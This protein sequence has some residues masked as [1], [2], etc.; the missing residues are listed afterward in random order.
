MRKESDEQRRRLVGR[1]DPP[2][3][4]DARIER[5]DLERSLARDHG[6][7]TIINDDLDTTVREILALNSFGGMSCL[8]LDADGNTASATTHPGRPNF[9][10]FMA[11]GD[12]E[13]VERAGRNITA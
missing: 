13:A 9:H 11:V 5:G 7:A 4:V 8:V 3:K 6:Y 12:A 2:E 10:W 1:G